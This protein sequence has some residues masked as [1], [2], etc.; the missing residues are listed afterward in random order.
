KRLWPRA[1]KRKIDALAANANQVLRTYDLS[2]PLRV[3]HFMAQVSHENDA[4]T[5]IRE[6]M[7]FSADRLCEIFGVGHHSARITHEEAES[8]AHHGEAIAERVYGIGN[9]R[10]SVELG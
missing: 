10:K 9:P 4:G 3:A 2:S 5:I 7:N 6:N 8:L 1:P